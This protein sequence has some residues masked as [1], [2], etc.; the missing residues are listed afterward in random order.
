MEN[1][2]ITK[3]VEESFLSSI[4]KD[5]DVT[6]ISYNGKNV[7]YYHNMKGNVKSDLVLNDNDVKDFLRQ[8]ANICEKQFSHQNPTLDVS[9]GRYRLNAVHQSIGR[10]KD[11]NTL[12]FC[13]RIATTTPRITEDSDFLTPE[14]VDFF[15]VLLENKDSIII[16][17]VTGS[18]KTEFQKY[19][20]RRMN[21]NTRIIIVDNVLELSQVLDDRLDITCWQADDRDISTS[22]QLLVR[23]ALR[24]NPDWLIVAESRGAEMIEV[25]NSA[26]TGHP[27]I[28]TLH[29]T[30]A[31][32]MPKRIGRMIMM[33]DKKMDL[34]NV[35]KDVYYQFHF[36]V[37]LKKKINEESHVV[38]YIS[39]ILFFD[40]NGKGYK[41]YENE[42]NKKLYGK[43]PKKYDI[44]HDINKEKHALFTKIFL[45]AAV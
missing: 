8:V 21:D 11:K 3:F 43:I 1:E 36:Y 7:F 41:M 25:L 22:I 29:A 32:S 38:R 28:T 31:L 30:D 10:Y 27:I 34:E 24:S 35:L 40:E 44:F 33:N 17:G 37:H 45:E 5:S 18:G 13:L 4:L 6:D 12:S 20:L 15:D 23:N 9:F 42:N 16:G 19:L 14:L 26:M 2:K 39:S